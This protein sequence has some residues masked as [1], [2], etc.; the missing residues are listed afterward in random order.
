M[1]PP[2]AHTPIVLFEYFIETLLA[3]EN[4]PRWSVIDLLYNLQRSFRGMLVN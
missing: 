4:K 1:C 3:D 2:E